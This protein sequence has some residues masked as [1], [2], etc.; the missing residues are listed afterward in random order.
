MFRNISNSIYQRY[1]INSHIYQI[2]ESME[3][4][5]EWGV[6]SMLWI[7]ACPKRLIFNN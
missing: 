7:M 1:S 5:S 3:V 6:M 2:S 4:E